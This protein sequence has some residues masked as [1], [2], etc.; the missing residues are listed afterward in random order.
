MRIGLSGS[1]PRAILRVLEAIADLFT[2]SVEHDTTTRPR[3]ATTRV[4]V[5]TLCHC[6]EFGKQNRSCDAV[7]T[8]AASD[9]HASCELTGSPTTDLRVDGDGKACLGVN[10]NGCDAQL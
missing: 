6:A 1:F 4:D 9:A 3:G 5:Q 10:Q 7:T 2:Q 8:A